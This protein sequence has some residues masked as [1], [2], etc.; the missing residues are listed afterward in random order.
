MYD[1]DR[2]R[3][4]VPTKATITI[5]EKD[6]KGRAVLIGS[7]LI[8]GFRRTATTEAMSIQATAPSARAKCISLTHHFS[9]VSTVAPPKPAAATT[10]TSPEML[11]HMTQL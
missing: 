10:S 7:D 9:S 5:F 4:K 11:G 6:L 8:C 3:A 2:I 1:P